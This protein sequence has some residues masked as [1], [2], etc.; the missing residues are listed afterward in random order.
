VSIAN[1]RAIVWAAAV[2]VL[3]VVPAGA[4][5]QQSLAAYFPLNP[6]T[7]WVYRASPNGEFILRVGGTN[8]V[9]PADCRVIETVIQGNVTQQECYRIEQDGVYT[10]QRDTPS[11]SV[12]L[13]PP[14]RILAS[15]VLVGEKWQWNGRVGQ[16][17][18]V[19]Y[20]TWSRRE[21][22]TTPAG[23]FST[24]QLYFEGNPA[25]QVRIQSWRWFAPGVGLV[26]EDTTLQQ[27]GQST[28]NYAELTQ[29]I[30]GK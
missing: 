17:P 25:P 2:V 24:M 10:Y 12:V 15:P 23:T 28:R 19:F 1:R 13:T 8:K 6:G 16:Q 30:M 27:G 7:V 14:Q 11:G 9:G 29:V 21:T 22:V 3:A 20:Y 18:V 5:Q 4:A 26:K